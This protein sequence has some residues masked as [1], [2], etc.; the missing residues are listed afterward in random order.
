MLRHLL[1]YH[2]YPP[3]L[4]SLECTH[5]QTFDVQTF[6]PLPTFCSFSFYMKTEPC[7]TNSAVI[8]AYCIILNR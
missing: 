2:A 7:H 3:V 5:V 6:W 4:Y 8:K 1:K